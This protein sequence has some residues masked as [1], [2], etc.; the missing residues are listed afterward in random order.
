MR[1][2]ESVRAESRDILNRTYNGDPPFDQETAE[3]NN[4][5]VNRN[6]LEGTGLLTDART[7]WNNN[8]LKPGDWA[9]IKVDCKQPHKRTEYS[10]EITKRW[11]RE[12]RKS[13]PMI[14]QA[15]ETG[16]TLLL[17]GPSPTYWQNRR[18]PIPKALSLASLLIPSETDIDFS[19]LEYFCIFRETTP[20]QLWDLTHGPKVDPGWNIPLV[21]NE[22]N[23]IGNQTQKMLNMTA[24]VWMPERITELMKQDGGFWGSD[25]VPTIDFWDFYYRERDGECWYRKSFLDWGSGNREVS[26]SAG[27]PAP[28]YVGK[29]DKDEP[30]WLYDGGKRKYADSWGEIIH[31]NFG[32]CSC[33]APFKYHSVRSLGWMNWGIVEINNRLQ[34]KMTEQAFS[35]L[36]WFFRVASGNDFNRLKKANFL[37]MGVIP[38]GIE[39]VK[40]NERFNPNPAFIEL[41]LEK[42][43]QLLASNSS[44]FTRTAEQSN[45]SNKEKTAT[46]VM[47]EVN[48]INTMVSG[49]MGLAYTFETFKYQE[50]A[51]R[52]CI[53]NNPDA[54]VQ[55]FRKGCIVD[56]GIPAEYLDIERWE[57]EADRAMGAGNKTVQM[58]IV[59]YLNSI[60]ANLGP[61]AQRQVDHD[62]ILIVTEDAAMA[63]D[64][65]PV[66]GQQPIG[67]SAHDAELATERL[68][69]GLPFT[70]TP[71]MVYEDY[72]QVWIRDMGLIVKQI[73]AIDHMGTPEEILGLNNMAGTISS[74]YSTSPNP[75]PGFLEIMSQSPE[76][77]QKSRQYSDLLGKLMNVV[78]GFS[79][80]LAQQA[81][82]SNGTARESVA[83]NYKDAPSDIQRQMEAAAGFQP[84]QDPTAQIN[85]NLV[86]AQHDIQTKDAKHKQA[87]AAQA[88]KTAQG[89]A[90]FELDQQNR[91]RE[92]S[93]QIR[94]DNASAA[95][96]IRIREIEA[97]AKPKAESE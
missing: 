19:N 76:G 80:R 41:V 44:S 20:S 38:Q 9:T 35:D 51:R 13:L 63:E 58:A 81:K 7:Q 71:Q 87:L 8:F 50:I 31:C 36:M 37:Q 92:T 52:F 45:S 60:R 17:H 78:K 96:D 2:A 68:M 94:R 66:A 23:F 12:L 1:L 70:P 46:Q 57:I 75:S 33:V 88:D 5:E 21:E 43:R 42:N 30:Q 83:I 69:R 86:K 34:S 79:Q 64:L 73:Q 55:R 72:V 93:A 27:S 39:W 14:M 49:V 77:A 29:G 18:S 62:G 91:D 10:T 84:S 3:E 89:Q 6:F 97:A 85:P 95:A 53:P 56:A 4:I 74:K 25:A 54:M 15:R 32:D 28:D 48:S 65:A 24:Y 40:G 61:D 59:Q 11:N 67:R 22:I 47:A 26:M 82:A 16:A 90:A